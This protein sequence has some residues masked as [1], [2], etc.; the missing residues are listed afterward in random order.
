M[1]IYWNSLLMIIPGITLSCVINRVNED[2]WNT[3]MKS[4]MCEAQGLN[5]NAM[6]F[7][8]LLNIIFDGMK[9]IV[10]PLLET[11]R[12]H[13]MHEQDNVAKVEMFAITISSL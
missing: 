4:L 10:L 3:L 6:M 7:I 5:I 11:S 8:Q 12:I 9:F 13:S 2:N 1:H